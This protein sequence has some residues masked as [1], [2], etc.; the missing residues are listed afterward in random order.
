[1][2]QIP[3]EVYEALT[4]DLDVEV[5]AF[6][7]AKAAHAATV[8][9]AAP[10]ANQLVQAVHAAGGYVVVDTPAEPEPPLVAVPSLAARK[11]RQIHEEAL[12]RRNLLAPDYPQHEID[13][14]DQ[15]RREA[16]AYLAWLHTNGA[17]TTSVTTSPDTPLLTAMATARGWT[18][19][20]LAVRVLQKAETFAQAGGEI[21]GRQQAAEDQLQTIMADLAA[22][23]ITEDEARD[24]IAAIEP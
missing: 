20:A 9:V 11:R 21:L 14:W 19:D 7:A 1:M 15:Q 6:A 10:V 4:F 22:G 13:T 17:S 18:I 5:D 12:R 2:I 23:T 16:V 8:G 24:L 3:R